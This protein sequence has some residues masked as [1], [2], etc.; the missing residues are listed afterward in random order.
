MAVDADA[1]EQLAEHSP[2][3]GSEAKHAV[4]D[5]E[6][7]GDSSKQIVAE[8]PSKWRSPVR[9]AVVVSAA[10]GVGLIALGGWL[11]Y[12]S[13][14][15][16]RADD[17]RNVFVEVAKQGAMNLTTIN[18]TEV[19]KDVQRILD[20]STGTFRDDFQKRAKPFIDVVKQMRSVSTGIVT[21]AGLESHDGNHAQVLVA[22]SVK[23]VSAGAPE[24]EPRRWRMR[25][26]V[27][28][29]GADAKVSNVEFVP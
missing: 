2:D 16:Q 20:S 25:I 3:V 13:H 5:I 29:N 12:D 14:R 1:I 4:D 27:Q 6:I 26:S 15:Y 8:A 19:D 10:T 17:Q 22:V 7:E 9:M 24:Q 11:G 21:D 23:T 28:D 18:Y